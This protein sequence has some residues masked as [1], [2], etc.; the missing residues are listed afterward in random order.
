MLSQNTFCHNKIKNNDNWVW[1]SLRSC[2]SCNGI[3]GM[4]QSDE[5]HTGPVVYIEV[6]SRRK[7]N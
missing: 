4:L 7:T 3:H 6:V 1:C 2:G 5:P